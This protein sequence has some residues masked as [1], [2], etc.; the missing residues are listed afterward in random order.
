MNQNEDRKF[1]KSPDESQYV[2]KREQL[3]HQDD[4]SVPEMYMLVYLA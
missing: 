3:P 4:A 1:K 2:E